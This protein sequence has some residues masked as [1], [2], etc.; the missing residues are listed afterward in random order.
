VNEAVKRS[1][2]ALTV[3][4]A[5]ATGAG[6]KPLDF[7]ALPAPEKHHNPNFSL[8]IIEDPAVDQKP[9]HNSGM[10]AQT[11]VM[12]GGVL[13]VGILKAAPNKF[14]AGEWRADPGAPRSRKAA[15]TFKLRF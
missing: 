4:M 9:V 10:I 11:E 3:A 15:V 8:Q 14:G 7:H 2:A 12:P 13:G 1:I 6:A 5:L